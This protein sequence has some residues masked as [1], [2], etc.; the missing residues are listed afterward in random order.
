MKLFWW[1]VYFWLNVVLLALVTII[2]FSYPSAPVGLF[3]TDIVVYA[4]G[5]TGVYSYIFRKQIFETN[6][7]RY[8]FWFNIA[9]SALFLLYAAAPEHPVIGYLSFLAYSAD[10]EN[11]LL[12]TMVGLLLSLPYMFAMYQL[13]ANRYLS[14]P[15]RAKEIL[16]KNKKWGMIQM[17]FWGYSLIFIC[18]LLVLSLLPTTSIESATTASSSDTYS[19]MIIFAPILIFW[20][21]ITLEYKRYTWNWWKVTLLL[22]SLLFSGIIV[23]GSLFFDPLTTVETSSEFDWIG[24]AQTLIILTGLYVFG[25]EQFQKEEVPV[26]EP[27]R[28]TRR[29]KPQISSD[30]AIGK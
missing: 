12:N 6:F 7:W 27:L 26:I 24:V 4:V 17:A 21:W 29:R 9:Y 11:L 2:E 5:L 1:K 19:G 3:L 28:K 18:V 20:L 16:E 22:N 10:T 13:A 30:T 25:S 23:F 8:F 14:I 15:T